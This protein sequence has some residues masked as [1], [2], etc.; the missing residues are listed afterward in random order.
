MDTASIIV[1]TMCLY[2]V[3]M[4]C[5]RCSSSTGECQ[6]DT[7]QGSHERQL[8]TP[9]G[10]KLVYNTGMT[11][12]WYIYHPLSLSLSHTH[13]STHSLTHPLTHSLIHS[14]T[15]S[16]TNS[17]IHSLTHSLLTHPLIPLTH[18]LFHTLSLTHSFSRSLSLSL[19]LRGYMSKLVQK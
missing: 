17:L 14:L 12:F 4:T 1:L 9:A 6:S 15:H 10:G 13:S 16:L 19:S 7:D 18:S 5:L 2:F 8:C 3:L 11:T